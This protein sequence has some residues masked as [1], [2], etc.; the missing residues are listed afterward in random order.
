MEEQKTQKTPAKEIETALK[1]KA[2]WLRR[3]QHG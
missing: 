2:D 1:Y 3:K